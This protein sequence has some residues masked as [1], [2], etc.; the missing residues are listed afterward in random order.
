MTEDRVMITGTGMICSLGSHVPEVWEA[1]ISGKTGI[2]IIDGFDPSGFACSLA[3]QVHPLDISDLKIHPR[4]ARIMDTPSFL[5]LKATREAFS[6]ARLEGTQIPREEIGFFAGMGM[7]DHD[8][9]DLL[10]AVLKSLN[11]SGELDYSAF[12]SGGYMEV[13]PLW[14]LSM[15][16]NIGFCQVGTSL[17]LQG[18]NTVFSPHADSGVMAVAEGMKSVVDGRANVALCGGVSE[19]VTPFSLAR[20]HLCGVLN[21]TAAKDSS[22]CRPFNA[23]RRGTILGEGAGVIALELESSARRRG[24]EPLA[25]VAGYGCSCECR[26]GFA[27]PTARAMTLAMENALDLSGLKPSEIDL[28]MAHGDGTLAGDRNEIEAIQHVFSGCIESLHVFSSKGALGHLLAGAPLVDMILGIS[29]MNHG[30]IPATLHTTIPDPSIRFH[31]VHGEPVKKSVKRIL[32]NCQSCEG[33]AASIVL[34]AV[35]GK[36]DPATRSAGACAA[37]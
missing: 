36:G 19:K 16:N 12:Y 23:E 15:L 35:G 11:A 24:V 13:Y 2:R 28:V 9:G 34:E 17:D 33:Q 25:A 27:G 5:L 1:L 29:T 21:T 37:C 30:F 7:I 6:N 18:E 20:A 3:A 32:V 31:L 8:I 22:P 14:P 26:G 4:D 10:P